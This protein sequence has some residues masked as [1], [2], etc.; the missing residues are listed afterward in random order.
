MVLN[1]LTIYKG[2]SVHE[3]SLND[4]SRVDKLIETPV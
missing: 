2:V 4:R 1:C 3:P